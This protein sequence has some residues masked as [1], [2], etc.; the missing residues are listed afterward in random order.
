MELWDQNKLEAVIAKKHAAEKPP[1]NATDIVC[2]HFMQAVEARKYGWFWSCP[3]GAECKYRHKLPKG[4]VFKSD[5]V[6]MMRAAAMNKKSD[7]DDLRE[8]LEK[9]K[10][11]GPGTP[12]TLDVFL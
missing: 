12:V 5:L 11:S 1:S 2:K 9:L 7:Q 4:F 3:G 10:D 8:A 6:A